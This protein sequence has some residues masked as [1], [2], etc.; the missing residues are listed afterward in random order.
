M[1]WTQLSSLASSPESPGPGQRWTM[2]GEIM[3]KALGSCRLVGSWHK[4]CANC[5]VDVSL[6]V[7]ENEEAELTKGICVEI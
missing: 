6:I 2:A 5:I 7:C 1:A 3:G 4:I